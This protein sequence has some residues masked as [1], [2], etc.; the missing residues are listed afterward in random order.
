MGKDNVP[1]HTVGFPCT[2]IGVNERRNA[3]G[4]WETVNDAPWKL[5]DQLKGFNWLD[6][7][8][9]KFSTSQQRGVFMDH[10]LELLAPDYW[11]W[12]ITANT[13]ETSD[14]TFTWE[15]FQMQVNADLAD[16]LGNFVN[17][18]LKFTETRFDGAVPAGG[19]PGPL[20]EKLEADVLAKLRELTGH[21]EDR[22][23][24]KSAT[25]LRQLWVL[26][27]Q[28]LTEAAPWTAIKTDPERAAVVVRYGL[29]LVALFAKVSE[30]VIPFAAETIA[31][32]V[33]E[34]FPGRWPSLDGEGV[35]AALEPGRKV[36]APEVL[37]RKV[38]DTQVADWV[39]RFGGAEQATE[40]ETET[41]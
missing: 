4:S 21:M 27:N 8:G 15:Q 10:A 1:F 33:G 40:M 29:N 25:A 13:P 22:E 16:V 30:P 20:E 24:R 6:Y 36:A 12:W 19:A 38:E 34:S 41:A 5:V 7:Y 14:A 17:R 37:F 9:G 3:D 2:L 35:L 18:I 11:R 26:G 28:Y 32:S 39:A 31:L 23:F